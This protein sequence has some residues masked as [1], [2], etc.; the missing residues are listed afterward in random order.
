MQSI[1]KK[2]FTWRP[3]CF[4]TGNAMWFSELVTLF[5]FLVAAW[6]EGICSSDEALGDLLVAKKLPQDISSLSKDA[7]A[8][9]RKLKEA[10]T[11]RA[12]CP[13]CY[14]W[15]LCVHVGQPFKP[16]NCG[17]FKCI[18]H[19]FF[20]E[21]GFQG[22]CG[23]LR[24]FGDISQFHVLFTLPFVQGPPA[25]LFRVVKGAELHWS[26]SHTP[27]KHHRTLGSAF[28]SHFVRFI[29][30]SLSL[31]NLLFKLAESAFW[32]HVSS[33]W[34][35]FWARTANRVILSWHEW[36][37]P[38]FLYWIDTGNS[39]NWCAAFVLLT[40]YALWQLHLQ[41]SELKSS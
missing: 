12:N 3:R 23:G 38:F 36:W 18:A 13:Q 29:P 31:I 41:L 30:C 22:D 32:G 39:S 11:K 6:F 34:L 19:W 17:F 4:Q 9:T 28:L 27:T 5:F 37:S 21:P 14:V 8:V 20:V 35:I 25:P 10:R 26:R 24:A 7:D 1:E 15:R 40:H 33:C 16:L 2:R